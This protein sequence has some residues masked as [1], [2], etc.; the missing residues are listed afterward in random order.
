[1]DGEISR[2][3]RTEPVRILIADDHALVR[4]GLRMML[5]DEPGLEVIGEASNGREALELCRS[6]K[7]DLVLM[8]VWM[9]E[10]DGL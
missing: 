6:L 4:G 3:A 5:E 1:V 10:M 7:P 8:D 2:E 9:P